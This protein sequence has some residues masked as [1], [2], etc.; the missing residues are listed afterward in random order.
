[1]KNAYSITE[2]SRNF[3]EYINRVAYLGERFIL[4]RGKK[5][6]AEIKPV[7]SSKK[8]SE[9]PALLASL[10][11]LSANEIEE[12]ALDIEESAKEIKTEKLR[13]AWES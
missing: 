7:R 1:M 12:F 6:V 10:P 13:D 2:V 3:S 11:K 5:A 8:L 4:M 9:L